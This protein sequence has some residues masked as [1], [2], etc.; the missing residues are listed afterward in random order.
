MHSVYYLL[1]VK[2]AGAEAK[3]FISITAP[4]LAKVAA[5]APQHCYVGCAHTLHDIIFR[6]PMKLL[7]GK[8]KSPYLE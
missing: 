8:E 5:L 1:K 4:A 6:A 2:G 7:Y 3:N